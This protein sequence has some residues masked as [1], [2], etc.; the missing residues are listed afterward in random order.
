MGAGPDRIAAPDT[1]RG[2]DRR[3]GRFSAEYFAGSVST[4]T[5]SSTPPLA[6][7]P[8][9]RSRR[10]NAGAA[11]TVQH[12]TDR[13]IDDGDV[14]TRPNSLDRWGRCKAA[15]R[16]LEMDD[17]GLFEAGLKRRHHKRRGP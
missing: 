7:V 11:A 3:W 2:D 14:A 5:A 17:V 16:L 9:A 6:S 8:A 12:A 13:K 1:A 15:R 4:I 10:W